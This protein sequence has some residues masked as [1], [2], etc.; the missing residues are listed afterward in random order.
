MY[1]I[2]I[3]NIKAHRLFVI[4]R[5]FSLKVHT[6]FCLLRHYLRFVSPRIDEFYLRCG[7]FLNN[8][9]LERS[10]W[11]LLGLKLLR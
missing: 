2:S 10:L 5:R 4:L 9:N 6:F 7:R 1:R 11:L 8:F 3:R